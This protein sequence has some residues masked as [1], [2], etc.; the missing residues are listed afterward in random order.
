MDDSVAI[1]YG[2]DNMSDHSKVLAN[3]NQ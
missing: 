1:Q 2:V 3:A